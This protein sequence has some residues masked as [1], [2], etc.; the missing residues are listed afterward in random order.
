MTFDAHHYVPILKAKRGEK[1]ALRL[2]SASIASKVTPLLEIV[3]R[4]DKEVS[5]HLDTAFKDLA[6]AVQLFCRSFIDTREIASDGP[7]AA[8]A[9]FQRAAS[10]GIVF[11]PVTG[12]SRT[13]DVSAAM[14]HRAHGLALRLSRAEF[15]AGSLGQ[16]LQLFME[17]HGLSPEDTD[18][19]VD[20]GAVDEMVTA[21]VEALAGAFLSEVPNHTRWKTLTLSACAF[22]PGMG[23]VDRHSYDLVE[24]TD[25]LA[26]G[27]GQHARRQLL[28]RLPTFSDG[29]IQHP[30]GVEGFDPRTMQVS[31]SIR[32]TASDSWLRIKGESTRLT[33]P[34][35]QFRSLATQLVYG[36][37]QPHYHGATHCNGCASIK[38]AADGIGRLGSLEV[39]RRLGTAHHIST[40][41]Q[42]LGR[43]PWP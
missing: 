5:D 18:L 29:A 13:V 36:H 28:P 23:G 6:D 7:A 10:D 1:S 3:A 4:T 21:G 41:V 25:W 26:W 15:E 12:I 17:Q 37:L 42:Q 2:L 24:R 43:L 8:G 22:P 11:T 38:A 33:P 16:R 40:V 32:Y 27:H 34:S 31:A 9:A 35:T 39:W 14:A 20:L 19:I 30:M